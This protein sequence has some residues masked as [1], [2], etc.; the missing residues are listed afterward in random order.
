MN[1]REGVVRELLTRSGEDMQAAAAH[2]VG[3]G[4]AEPVLLVLD[5][6]YPAAQ[7]LADRMGEARRAAGAEDLPQVGSL[8]FVALPRGDAVR[9]FPKDRQGLDPAPA[10]HF[11]FIAMAAGRV[12]TGSMRT[13]SDQRSPTSGGLDAP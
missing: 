4:M 3:R 1:D 10:G 9:L 11:L 6:T 2:A 8:V 13:A 5:R 12:T 7:A